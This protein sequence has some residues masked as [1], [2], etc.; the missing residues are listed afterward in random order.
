MSRPAPHM[1]I[2]Y[3]WM[4]KKIAFYLSIFFVASAL[5]PLTEEWQKS[6]SERPLLLFYDDKA[7][8]MGTD[9]KK[10]NID[11]FFGSFTK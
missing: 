3:T 6:Y 4:R 1:V 2:R 7:F 9:L 10:Y 5:C 11:T 8:Y